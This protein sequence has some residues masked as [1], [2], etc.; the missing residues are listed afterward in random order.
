VQLF[1][2]RNNTGPLTAQVMLHCA[3]FMSQYTLHLTHGAENYTWF[4]AR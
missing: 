3:P 2:Q 1:T 4:P